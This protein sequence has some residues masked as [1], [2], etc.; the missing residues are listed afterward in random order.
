MAYF[1]FGYFSMKWKV[2]LHY[3]AFY[4]GKTCAE[5]LNFSL[6]KKLDLRKTKLFRDRPSSFAPGTQTYVTELKKSTV[7]C[8]YSRV[9]SVS[10]SRV[11]VY[12]YHH[13]TL[14][15]AWVVAFTEIWK[16]TWSY[17]YCI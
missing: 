16:R 2:I 10:Q 9:K 4:F 8:P 17:Y 11:M 3:K 6:P 12:F 14:D 5:T 1:I 13:L 15:V 7:I